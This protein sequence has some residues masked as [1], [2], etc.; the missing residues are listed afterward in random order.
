MTQIDGSDDLAK[1]QALYRQTEKGGRV[2]VRLHL[3]VTDEYAAET[4]RQAGWE[5]VAQ[6]EDLMEL[7]KRT[8]PA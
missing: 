3:D 8:C 5:P 6:L 2:V 7:L 4:A 1:L